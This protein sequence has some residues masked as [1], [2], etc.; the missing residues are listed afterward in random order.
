MR[1]T[2]KTFDFL[3]KMTQFIMLAI[4]ATVIGT[5]EGWAWWNM[6]VPG[7]AVFMAFSMVIF[8]D[9]ANWFYKSKMIALCI[10]VCI[11]YGM[12]LFVYL[13]YGDVKWDPFPNYGGDVTQKK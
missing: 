6:I 12:N 7:G 4:S 8:I 10:A 13:K 2:T 1:E 9:A 5:S 3:F 11:L